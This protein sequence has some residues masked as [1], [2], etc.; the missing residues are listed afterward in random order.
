MNGTNGTIHMMNACTLRRMTPDTVILIRP[1]DALYNNRSP[2]AGNRPG[3]SSDSKE[4]LLPEEKRP[5]SI[6]IRASHVITIRISMVFL[7]KSHPLLL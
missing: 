5:N 7:M 4:P 3:S 6:A 2:K 1:A